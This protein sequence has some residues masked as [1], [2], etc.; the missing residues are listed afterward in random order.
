MYPKPVDFQF[1]KDLMK[2][3]LVLAGIAAIGFTYTIVLMAENDRG[4]KK[5][6]LR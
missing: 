6:F 3:V 5:I 4:L 1:T 2:F